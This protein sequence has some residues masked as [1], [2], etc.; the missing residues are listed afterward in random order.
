[1]DLAL[2]VPPGTD[3]DRARLGVQWVVRDVGLTDNFVNARGV[4]VD[5]TIPRDSHWN[6][7]VANH[8]QVFNS[9]KINEWD[10]W[11]SSLHTS[12]IKNLVPSAPN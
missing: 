10:L 8:G 5:S 12:I 4:P 11:N 3:F 9:V 2:C 1:M 7:R 6:L